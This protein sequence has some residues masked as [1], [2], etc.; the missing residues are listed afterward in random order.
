[1][2]EDTLLKSLEHAPSLVAILLIVFAFLKFLKELLLS[3]AHRTDEFVEVVRTLHR[4]SEQ[5]RVHSQ[6]VIE[7]NTAEIA[8]VAESQA[9][10]TE[11]MREMTEVFRQFLKRK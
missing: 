2:L 7:K 8:R 11:A 5:G 4:E 9:R 3:H 1:M 6:E 10:N